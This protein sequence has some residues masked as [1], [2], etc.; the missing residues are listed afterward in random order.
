MAEETPEEAKKSRRDRLLRGLLIVIAI[1]LLAAALRAVRVVAMPLVFAFFVAI[2]LNPL[3]HGMERRL[4]DKLK[5]LSL[6]AVMSLLVLV[7]AAGVG[8]IW[9]ALSRVMQKAPDYAERLQ[10]RWQQL[11]EWSEQH[12]IGLREE[13]LSGDGVMDRSLE[14]LARVME[15]GGALL[16]GLALVFFLVLLMLIEANTWYAKVRNLL[17]D[18]E[19]SD[20]LEVLEVTGSKVRQYLSVLT[21]MSFAAAFFHTLWLWGMG[22]EF[23]LLWGLMAFVLN[24]IPSIGA[25]LAVIAPSVFALLEFGPA[26]ALLTIAGMT[27]IEQ[28]IGNFLQPRM[29]GRRLQLSPVV[30][31]VSMLFWGWLWGIGGALLAV[32]ITI[33][34]LVVFAHLE[35]LRPVA[36]LMSGTASL[37]RLLAKTHNDE[38]YK[39]PKK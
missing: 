35:P 7:L 3:K 2:L 27:V 8:A 16:A 33:T 11:E 18:Y 21:L 12:N 26:W 22:L 20:L 13:F 10:D 32:P 38:S 34:L 1:I 9:M 23:F 6:V 19:R 30:V 5:W 36:Q 15:G 39:P 37:D 4:P 31:M 14:I 25:T 24:F 17:Q 28:V 29:Q